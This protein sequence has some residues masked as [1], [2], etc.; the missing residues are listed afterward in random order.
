MVVKKT[1]NPELIPG[2]TRFG[3]SAMYQKKRLYKHKPSQTKTEK[4][5]K[6][7]TFKIKQIKNEKGT[8]NGKERKIP[9]KRSRRFYP[10]EDVPKL[11]PNRKKTTPVK[12]RSKITPG[13]VLILLSGRFRGRRV[14][15]LK[16]LPS[17][18]LL[19]NGPFKI[20]G[21]PLRRVNQ[22]Y[23]IGTSTKVDL[24]GI[25]I[26]EKLNDKYF[27]RPKPLKSKKTEQAFF[28][29]VKEKTPIDEGRI[30][31]QK[32]SD[33]ALLEAIKKTPFLKAYL[34]SS[35]TL[36]TAEAPH[37]MKF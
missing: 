24:T 1:R 33:A 35:F 5:K 16:Q 28:Q 37:D 32:V 9:L 21:V 23:V 20:N 15:F 36:H 2:I 34:S 30:A 31:D 10:A 19:V 22:A 3:R 25:T 18:L 26:D 12:L 27:K 13:T 4:K 6:S 8:I 29:Q 7:A 11:L 14:V 17:G